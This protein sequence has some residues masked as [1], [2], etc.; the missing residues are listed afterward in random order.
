M[1]TLFVQIITYGTVAV[2]IVAL[3]IAGVVAFTPKNRD[4]HD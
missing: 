4:L 2:V 3:F 1:A